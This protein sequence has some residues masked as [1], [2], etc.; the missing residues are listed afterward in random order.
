MQISRFNVGVGPGI[1]SQSG[2]QVPPP[3]S[4]K[5]KT[6]P[7]P[8]Q[9]FNPVV[10]RLSHLPETAGKAIA[11]SAS[12][13][14]SRWVHELP[15]RTTLKVAN[16]LSEGWARFRRNFQPLLP[17]TPHIRRMGTHAGISDQDS[18]RRPTLM[19]GRGG[20]F[21]STWH[22]PHNFPY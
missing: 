9:P 15:V 14:A 6:A 20:G 11:D 12:A 7:I 8:A 19:G 2:P 22:A 13:R 1:N 21:G 18:V 4:K 5:I 3:T 17:E 16:W 10:S